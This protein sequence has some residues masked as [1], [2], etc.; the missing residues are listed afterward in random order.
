[1]KPPKFSQLKTADNYAP[2]QV[3]H[4]NS[5]NFPSKRWEN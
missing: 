3:S 1:M 2:S 5:R 4:N